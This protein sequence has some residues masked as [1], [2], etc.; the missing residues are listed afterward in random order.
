[1]LTLSSRRLATLILGATLLLS[2]LFVSPLTPALADG[3]T[4]CDGASCDMVITDPGSGGGGGGNTGGGE[5]TPSN[6][7]GS[8]DFTPGP[9]T[10]THKGKTI[11]AHEAPA[12]PPGT[13]PKAATGNS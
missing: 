9:K 6:D 13:T 12:D 5:D 2:T 4:E 8:T 7:E 10:C 3:K 11:P 1:M